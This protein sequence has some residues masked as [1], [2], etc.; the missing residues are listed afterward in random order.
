[1]NHRRKGM[2]YS[3]KTRSLKP[4][5]TRILVKRNNSR[6]RWC[7][8]RFTWKNQRISLPSSL[9]F[10]RWKRGEIEEES[11]CRTHLWRQKRHRCIVRCPL[12][13]KRRAIKGGEAKPIAKNAFIS[14]KKKKHEDESDFTRGSRNTARTFAYGSW[15]NFIVPIPKLLKKCF[16]DAAAFKTKIRD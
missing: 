16:G 11:F 4:F 1:M 15:M 6:S 9:C 5:N 12:S 3:W 13:R 8:R 10:P 14:N 2:C 7:A